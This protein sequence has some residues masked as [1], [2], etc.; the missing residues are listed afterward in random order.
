[1][2]GKTVFA[3]GRFAS[4]LVLASTLIF[5]AFS[6][7]SGKRVEEMRKHK[8]F[9]LPVGNGLEEIGVVRG[10][11]RDF[12]GPSTVLFK[13]GFFYIVDFV[14]QK[15]LKVTTPGDI[16]L[17]LSKGAPQD[18]ND[19]EDVL[20]LK[21]R[22]NYPFNTIGQ[23]TVDSENN[24]YVED[25][26]LQ[27]GPE[28][29]EIDVI[30]SRNEDISTDGEMYVSYVLKF[31]RLGKYV[32][33]V[34]KGGVDS[35]PFGF[36]YKMDVDNDGNLIVLTCE[37]EWDKWTYY[38]FNAE[39]LLLFYSVISSD[40]IFSVKD[41]TDVQF[42]ILDV[43]PVLN[44]NSLIFW[45]SLYDTTGDTKGLNRE[46]TIWS[47]EIEIKNEESLKDFSGKKEKEYKRDLLYY[48]LL[49]YN[50]EKRTTDKSYRWENRVDGQFM[51]T[52][53]LFGID[54]KSNGFLWRYVDATKAIVTIFRPNGTQ[55]ARRSFVFE[56]TGIWSA[57]QVAEDGSVTGVRID[58]K[59]LT[60]YRWNTDDLI[61]RNP[62]K[63]SLRELIKGA[64][65]EFRNANR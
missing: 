37:E 49:Y 11:S 17:V 28:K 26:L 35:E 30:G 60:F 9:V 57:V 10:Q 25:K 27:K 20:R 62:R 13:N 29:K 44:S 24:L 54:G 41:M 19:D 45:V 51:P 31:D 53:E 56:D 47:E 43:L 34:G 55:V 42:F 50:L 21:E 52:E 33:K 38:K 46:E 58:D 4:R 14:N 5:T 36:I 61:N 32:C 59:L 65:E 6:G 63:A 39:G 3:S 7:C 15:L 48:K 12:T 23:I 16:I 18:E 8:L 40:Q 64:I 2:E 22:R 1:M